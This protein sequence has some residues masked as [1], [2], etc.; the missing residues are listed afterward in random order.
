MIGDQSWAYHR[1][2]TNVSE[3]AIH[4]HHQHLPHPLRQ[5]RAS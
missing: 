5:S 1:T 2:D 3:G 4:D